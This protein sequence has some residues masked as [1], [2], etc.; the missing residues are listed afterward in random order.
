MSRS[1]L[2]LHGKGT[3]RAHFRT[4]CLAETIEV[5][6][7]PKMKRTRI[8]TVETERVLVVRRRPTAVEQWCDGCGEQARMVRAEE[9]AALAC[10]G[11]REICRLVE[12]AGLHFN[13]TPEGR[14]FICL[15]SLKVH[16]SKKGE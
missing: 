8:I 7:E 6:R 9:A 1:T 13:E 16:L 14:L 12:V 15:N 4:G 3:R 2:L 10:V 11:L 5:T